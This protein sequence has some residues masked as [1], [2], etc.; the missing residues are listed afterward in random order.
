MP[1][2]VLLPIG[3]FGLHLA[4]QEVQR[5]INEIV[6][7][8][9]WK[10]SAS[11]YRGHP[12]IAGVRKYHMNVRGWS[13]NG[14]H[15]MF[16]TNGDLWRCRPI[17]RAGAHTLGR[18]AHTVG[19]SYVANFDV[20]DPTAYPGWEVGIQATAALVARFG[21]TVNDIRF[22]NEFASKTCPGTKVN[23]QDYR[24]QVQAVLDDS[25]DELRVVYIPGDAVIHCN[26]VVED[27]VARVDI[28][29]LLE[30]LGYDVY[31]HIE[32]QGKIYVRE[33]GK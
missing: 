9:C 20:D 22:H 8:H 15:F 14:Y 16:G 31:D 33:A 24:D 26:P 30:V 1:D 11:D 19:I 4:Q 5:T 17:Q 10:P 21:L 29:N 13:D 18:N 25:D 32:D 3:D 7:H 6:V 12:T 23:L 28:R 2:E 27:G